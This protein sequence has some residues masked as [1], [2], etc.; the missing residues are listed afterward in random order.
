M[1]TAFA[2]IPQPARLERLPGTFTRRTATVR[3]TINKTRATRLGEEGYELTVTPEAVTIVAATERGA[4]YGRKTLDQL[5]PP[6]IPCLRIIDRPRFS[7]RGMHL[8]VGRH[9]F[10]V[11]Q[12]KRYLDL[13]ALHKLNTFHFHLTEDQGWR[14]AIKK[15]PRLTKIGSRRAETPLPATPDRGDGKP[16]GGFYTQKEIR[17]IVAY[18]A[19]RHITVVPEIEMPGHS[20]AALAAYPE[21]SCTGG[22]FAVRTKWGI[23]PDVYCAGNDR[24]F[25]FLEDVL[26]EALG[27]FPSEFIHIGGDECPKDRWQQCPKCQARIRAEGLKNEHGLQS[28]FI[29]RIEKFLNARGRRLIGWDEILEGGL[30]P[31]AAVMSWRG[32]EGGLAAAAAGHDAVMTPHTHCYFNY[33]QSDDPAEPPAPKY[34]VPL[35][36]KQV[37]DYEPIPASLPADQHHHILGAQGCLWTE[38]IPTWK[39]VEHMVLPRMCA[40]AEVVWSPTT[41]RDYDDFRARL[42][43]RGQHL[44]R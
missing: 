44:D 20:L 39:V 16:Y 9:F 3:T 12:I 33:A 19:A 28:S 1:K 22:P 36:L 31:N 4:F 38:Y 43:R 27:L 23:E 42:R 21:L 5:G 25:T 6:P 32:T 7:W 30:A 11:Q 18:A 24:V 34:A 2:I 10:P 41:A 35:S 13:L 37:Y 29:R 14:I 15:Y 40:L 26:D 17:E 8:D